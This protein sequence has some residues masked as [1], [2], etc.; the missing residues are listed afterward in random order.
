MHCSGQIKPPT[1]GT[2]LIFLPGT[3]GTIDWSLTVAISQIQVR[4]WLFNS[5]DGSRTG[6]L[7]RIVDDMDPGSKDISLIPRFEIEKP[8]TLIL[9]NVDQTYNGM[10]T[11]TVLKKGVTTADMSEVTVYIAGKILRKV[12][13][14]AISFLVSQLH[15]MGI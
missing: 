13:I 6:Q 10:Y 12:K 4:T 8:A 7:T 14:N 2:K 9:M 15:C 5:R 1:N 11:F 3:N